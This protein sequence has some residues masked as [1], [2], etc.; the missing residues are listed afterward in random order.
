MTTTE[1]PQGRRVRFTA[2][3]LGTIDP[4]ATRVGARFT[5]HLVSRGDEGAVVIPPGTMPEGWLAV[6]PDD[7][8]DEYVPVHPS[9]IEAL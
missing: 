6:T 9:M 5:E 7:Y 3:T 8:P 1:F 4:A 2:D